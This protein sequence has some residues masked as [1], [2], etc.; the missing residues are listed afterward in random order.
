MAGKRAQQAERTCVLL[1][2][3][4]AL[5]L[6]FQFVGVVDGTKGLFPIDLSRLQERIYSLVKCLCSVDVMPSYHVVWDLGRA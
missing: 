6:E 2:L 3:I 4:D 1:G 5:Q